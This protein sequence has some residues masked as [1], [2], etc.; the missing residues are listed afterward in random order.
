VLSPDVQEHHV[1][2]DWGLEAPDAAN[3]FVCA[4]VDGFEI[5]FG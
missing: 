2:H 4:Q 3:I 1:A 5:L